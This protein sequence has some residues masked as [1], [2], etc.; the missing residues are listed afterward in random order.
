MSIDNEQKMIRAGRS[1]ALIYARSNCAGSPF[2]ERKNVAHWV[3]MT[4]RL[5]HA[6]IAAFLTAIVGVFPYTQR[7]NRQTALFALSNMFL[8]LW[9]LTDLVFLIP[10]HNLMLTLYRAGLMIGICTAWSFNRFTTSFG[11]PES[12]IF[13]R[14]WMFLVAAGLLSDSGP[15]I[16]PDDLN[17]LFEPWFTTKGSRGMGIGLYLSREIIRRHGGSVEAASHSGHGTTFPIGLPL[18]RLLSNR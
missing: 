9:N 18:S 4:P 6:V 12:T 15:G 3:A 10:D 11:Q 14:L 16:L 2:T 17:R 1:I 13:R 8:V 7:R 5:I